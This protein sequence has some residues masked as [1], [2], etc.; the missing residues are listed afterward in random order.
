VVSPRRTV[1]VLA[2]AGIVVSL[3]QTLVIPLV[4]QFP[5][6]LGAP[7]ADTAWV[8]TATLLGAAVATPVV[9]RLGDMYGKRRLLLLSLV[10]LV[11][12]SVVCALS[13][14]L[15]PMIAGR[16]LQGLASG[17]IPLGISIMRDA[18]PPERLGSSI[19][20][21]SASLGVGGALGLPGAALLIEYTSWH[22]IFWVAAALGAVVTTLVAIVVRRSPTRTGGRFDVLGAVGLATALVALLLAITRGAAW[23]WGSPLTLSLFA[24]AALVLVSWGWYQLRITQPLVDL[25]TTARRPLLFTNLASIAFGFA[26]FSVSLVLPQAIQL[27]TATGYGLGLSLLAVGLIMA[28]QGLVMMLFA[29]VSALI[30]RT[31]GPQVTVIV[32]SLTVAVG[33][34]VGVVFLGSVLEILIVSLVIGAGV[35]IAYGALPALVMSAT[36]LSETASANSLNTLMRALGTTVSSAVAGIVIS[37]L[38]TQ[39]RGVSV[40]SQEALRVVMALGSAAA[41]LTVVLILF[42]PRRAATTV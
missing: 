22:A 12:G 19:A 21:M 14:S 40:P 8:V 17:V 6:L 15:V 3:M 5:R 24:I 11:V 32:G 27:P 13:D 9:G 28:P 38:T 26:V 18:L 16:A 42:V 33:Y 23:G 39:L 20:L 2:F 41:I 10:L 31:R 25:R 34:A 1:A 35:G 37:Q 30:S 4:P 36:P 29:P 7:A